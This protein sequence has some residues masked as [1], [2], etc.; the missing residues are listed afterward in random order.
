MRWPIVYLLILCAL[1]AYPKSG[2]VTEYFLSNGL[3]VFVK[4]DHRVPIA[5]TQICGWKISIK[6]K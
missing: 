1:P 4:E 5:I 6:N 3:K 2:K